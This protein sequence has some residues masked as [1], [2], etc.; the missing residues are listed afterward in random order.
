MGPRGL[1]TERGAVS[2]VQ[3][4]TPSEQGFV[5]MDPKWLAR[6]EC[7]PTEPPGPLGGAGSTRTSVVV[8]CCC[9][10]L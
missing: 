6:V 1:R 2:L 10:V 9:C 5:G 3:V 7:G 8:V 4:T